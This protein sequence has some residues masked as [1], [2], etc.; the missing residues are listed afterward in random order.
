[1]VCPSP[2]HVT[3]L[4][5]R[6]PGMAVSMRGGAAGTP[7]AECAAGREE[8][9]SASEMW[10]VA[11][12]CALWVCAGGARLR[13]RRRPVPRRRRRRARWRARSG[14]SVRTRDS[15][16]ERKT[17]RAQRSAARKAGISARRP[18]RHACALARSRAC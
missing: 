12:V 14:L 6:T 15:T 18:H 3:P 2:L 8:E 1:M 16:R 4:G 5:R 9:V 10:T 7:A 17:R 11:C 13:T